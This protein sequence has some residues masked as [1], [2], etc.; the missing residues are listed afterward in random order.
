MQL[1]STMQ[2]LSSYIILNMQMHVVPIRAS[3]PQRGWAMAPG[4]QAPNFH[5]YAVDS[6]SYNLIILN[7]LC[8]SNSLDDNS[9][10][11][12]LDR[13]TQLHDINGQQQQTTHMQHITVLY[14]I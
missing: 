12:N 1:D 10:L 11:Y 6:T 8:D 2:L 9:Q 5:D 3:S 4:H 13:H 7:I 14:I